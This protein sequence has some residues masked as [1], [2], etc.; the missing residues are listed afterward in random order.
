MNGG[1]AMNVKIKLRKRLI[2][3]GISIVA[4]LSLTA[5]GETIKT[6]AK[7]NLSDAVKQRADDNIRIVNQLYEASLISDKT[8]D[9][10]VKN[11]EDQTSKIADLMQNVGLKS[12]GKDLNKEAKNFLKTISAF[13]CIQGDEVGTLQLDG[14]DD[15]SDTDSGGTQKDFS[16]CSCDDSDLKTLA[17][18]NFLVHKGLANEG[19]NTKFVGNCD[20][21]GWLLWENISC[22]PIELVSQSIMDEVNKKFD[23]EV[24]VLSPDITTKDGTGSIDGIMAL[25]QSAIDVGDS[26]STITNI[27]TL[28]NYFVKAV[29]ANGDP[30]KLLQDSNGEIPKEYQIIQESVLHLETDGKR[31]GQDLQITQWGVPCM[32]LK[33]IE[34]NQ[35]AYDN[36]NQLMGLNSNKYV[37]YTKGDMKRVYLMEYPVSYIKS[38]EQDSAD[39]NRV[40]AN[41]EKSGLGIN[42]LTGDIIKYDG[43]VNN[44]NASGTPVNSSVD[45]YL[46]TDGASSNNEDGLSAFIIKGMTS[47]PISYDLVTG[48]VSK[49]IACGRIIL[50]DYLEASFAPEFI[51]NESMVVFGRK[52]RIVFS[53]WEETTFDFTNNASYKQYN[54]YWSKNTNMAFYV[55][56]DGEEILTSPR[57][58]ITDFCDFESLAKTNYNACVVKSIVEQGQKTT[59]VDA[60]KFDGI[61]SIDDLKYKTVSSGEINPTYVF[62]SD[63]IGIQDWNSDNDTKQRFYCLAM[64][65]NLF[66]NALFSDWINSKSTVASLDWWNNYLDENG[67]KYSPKHELV[68]NYLM[69]NF[70]YQI[71]QSGI[72]I[73]D[74]ETVATIQEMYDDEANEQRIEDLHTFF[75]ILGWVLIIY[76]IILMLCWA[77]D[78][79]SDIGIKLLGK[80]TLGHWVAVKYEEDIPYNNTNELSYLT[81]G[82]MF[83]RCILIIV[84]GLALIYVNVFHVVV[85]LIE[86]FG[87]AA[88]EAEKLIE[89][90]R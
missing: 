85:M 37:F 48:N 66:E 17:F 1:T 80:L 33:F 47:T 3:V 16:G 51:P 8:K 88:S 78:T 69:N 81:G 54:P 68:N 18:T 32:Y 29:D 65:K 46:T 12:S 57:L 14:T 9:K 71:S 56:K 82:K 62:P 20:S 13:R 59:E 35:D 28:N 2:V 31:L 79:N 22:E 72:I 53:N 30:V 43:S 52:I 38:I 84:M 60:K 42:L 50:R 73:L 83:L 24:Y 49:E 34:F 21:G 10:A 67:F 44:W 86:L 40:N 26:K 5:C 41:I 58:Q 15:D 19:P 77:L 25:L 64:N 74:L 63:K 76:S 61:P 45:A 89:G 75:M 39:P 11:I 27:G 4:L 55:N 6:F 70:Q 36:L 90:L 7:T 87:R 23:Y